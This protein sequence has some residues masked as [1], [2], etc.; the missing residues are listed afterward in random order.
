LGQ[1][2]SIRGVTNSEEND[3]EFINNR[4]KKY[5]FLHDYWISKIKNITKNCCIL[6]VSGESMPKNHPKIDFVMS[7]T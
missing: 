1:S 5:V 4:S 3:N 6:M 2:L 7:E